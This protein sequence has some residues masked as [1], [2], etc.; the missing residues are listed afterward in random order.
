MVVLLVWLGVLGACDLRWR[1]LPNLLTLPGFVVIVTVAGLD[2]R[3][4]A[5]ASGAVQT[6]PM[7]AVETAVSVNT[8][9]FCES[10]VSPV[11]FSSTVTG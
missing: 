3:G 4:A 6:R 9:V 7:M 2:G 11:T 5:A 10:G 1:R 8:N